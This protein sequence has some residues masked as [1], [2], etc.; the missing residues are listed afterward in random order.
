MQTQTTAPSAT[1]T[2]TTTSKPSRELPTSSA[3]DGARQVLG[4]GSGQQTKHRSHGFQTPGG[5]AG[6]AWE[7]LP[8]GIRKKV[9]RPQAVTVAQPASTS[10][11]TATQAKAKPVAEDAATRDARMESFLA[12]LSSGSTTMDKAPEGF[13]EWAQKQLASETATARDDLERDFPTLAPVSST[14]APR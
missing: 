5:L 2:T 4:G 13:R 3:T 9:P 1:A 11:S 6:R 14:P 10:T 12:S 8:P 7:Q